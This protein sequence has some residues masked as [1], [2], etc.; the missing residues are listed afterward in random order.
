MSAD[1]GCY[2]SRCIEPRGLA[3]TPFDSIADFLETHVVFPIRKDGNCVVNAIAH[4]LFGDASMGP[5]LRRDAFDY[6]AHH[7]EYFEAFCADRSVKVEACLLKEDCQFTDEIMLAAIAFANLVNYYIHCVQDPIGT[8]YYLDYVEKPRQK[9]HL[10]YFQ[11]DEKYY[12]VIKRDLHR[13]LLQDPILAC[14]NRDAAEAYAALPKEERDEM[15]AVTSEEPVAKGKKSVSFAR[16]PP[17]VMADWEDLTDELK[18]L[19]PHKGEDVRYVQYFQHMYKRLKQ[20]SAAGV[21]QSKYFLEILRRSGE[22]W[23]DRLA[24]IPPSTELADQQAKMR[25]LAQPPPLRS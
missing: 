22:K 19:C 20:S 17:E 24:A 25:T 6:M 10:V 1:K 3:D 2:I 5:E 4:Q 16:P 21:K 8:V 23:L 12:S 15:F 18:A 9:L 7:L 13:S 11:D 14:A